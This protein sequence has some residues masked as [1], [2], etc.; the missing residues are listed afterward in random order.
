MSVAALI[1]AAGASARLGRPK[2]LEPWGESSLLGHVIAQTALFPV[3]ET[4]VVLGAGI[5]EILD[6]V[7]FGDAGVI[8][9]PEWDEGIASSIRVGLDA[10]LQSSRCDV[11]LIVLGDQPN[12]SPH[13]VEELLISHRRSDHPVSVPKYRYNWGNPVAVDRSL[14]PRL[15]SL[16]GDG[17]ANRLWQAHPEWINEVWFPEMAPRDVDTD[18]DVVELRPKNLTQ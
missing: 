13:T 11:A 3:D 18:T 2:Q 9:N 5:D 10:L 14:W 15:M 1:L 4:W 16:E 17:G 6:S 8:E 7:E 12:V